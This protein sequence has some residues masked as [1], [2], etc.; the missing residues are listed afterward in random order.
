MLPRLLRVLKLQSLLS[1]PVAL[2]TK[3]KHSR[4]L[5]NWFKYAAKEGSDDAKKWADIGKAEYK[6]CNPEDKFVFLEKF[7]ATK[8]NKNKGWM[9]NF[10]E[11]LVKNKSCAKDLVEKYQS[12]H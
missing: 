6:A 10:K 11:T 1:H 3:R 5:R 8:D 12:K 2:Q 9:K 4:S 7:M